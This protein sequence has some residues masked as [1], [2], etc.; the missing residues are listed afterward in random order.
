VTLPLADIHFESVDDAVIAHIHGEVDMSNAEQ[1]GAALGSQ[2]PTDARALVLDLT[3]VGYLD[4]AGIRMIYNLR[5]RLDD[6]G[7]QLT[8]VLGPEAAIAETLRIA[9]VTRSV[10]AVETVEAALDSLEA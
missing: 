10:A 6:R 1:L 4:S 2:V 9:G 5:N 7:H 3:G 8:L